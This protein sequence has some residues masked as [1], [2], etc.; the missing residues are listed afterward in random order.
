MSSSHAIQTPGITKEDVHGDTSSTFTVSP[1]H[2][3]YGMTLGNSLRRV[4]L[5]SIAGSA[6]K[7]FKIEG[8]THEFTTVPGV[9]EDVVDIL[10][11]L[12]KLRFKLHAD[13][14]QT[15]RIEKKGKGVITGK[16]IK[17]TADVEVV[18]TD[19]VIATVDDAK[20]NFVMDHRTGRVKQTGVFGFGR[21]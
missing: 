8:I 17:T 4:L 2:T 19:Q 18:N 13:E 1:L 10:L 20:T 3:G 14:A 11:N 6:V 16:D 5:S 15:V 21:K 7:A 9:K 12:K